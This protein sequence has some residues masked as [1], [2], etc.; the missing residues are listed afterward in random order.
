[1]NIQSTP[2]RWAPSAPVP[3]VCVRE[4]S[5]R[6]VRGGMRKL[7]SRD[8]L[9]VTV[10]GQC[11]SY[12]DTDYDQDSWR[13]YLTY[14]TSISIQNKVKNSKWKLQANQLKSDVQSVAKKLNSRFFWLVC[15][16]WTAMK[17][18]YLTFLCLL[19]FL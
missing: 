18:I 2:L 3:S 12:R 14:L 8:Q 5:A 19:L 11:L 15:P 1:M 10:L 17:Q 16:V 4:V 13:C 9:Q 6:R 7:S